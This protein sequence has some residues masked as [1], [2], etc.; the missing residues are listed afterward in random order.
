MRS[1]RANIPSPV[2][3][4]RSPT[5]TNSS[6]SDSRSEYSS[7]GSSGTGVHVP[8]NPGSHDFSDPLDD[9]WVYS[10]ELGK[11]ICFLSS[12]VLFLHDMTR[13]SRA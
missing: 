5:T 2:G 3:S 12:T 13:V 6:R 9:D 8:S 10:D 11:D 4:Q 7:E 1:A